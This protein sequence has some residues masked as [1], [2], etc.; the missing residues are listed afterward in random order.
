MLCNR[1]KVRSALQLVVDVLGLLLRGC[2]C[3]IVC[4]GSC[5]DQDLRQPHLLR[6]RKIGLVVL[7]VLP[8]LRGAHVDGT[9]HLVAHHV[10]R[11]DAV[12]DVRLEVLERSTLRTRSLLKVFHRREVVLLANFVQPANYLGIRIDAEFLAL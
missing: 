2:N 8:L 1:R 9:A 5:R 6:L 11:D 7:V 4:I 3:S 12:A 10:A